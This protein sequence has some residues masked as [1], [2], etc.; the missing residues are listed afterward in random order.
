IE[1]G[2]DA[3]GHPGAQFHSLA[4]FSQVGHLGLLVHLAADAVSQI[5]LDDPVTVV[6]PD[7][8][9][10]GPDVAEAGAVAHRPEPG[11][12][13]LLGAVDQV[14]YLG[15]DLPDRHGESSVAVESLVDGSGV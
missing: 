10:G 3:Q 1:H 4:R 7:F 9:D 6:T 8:F 11:P 15:T 13:T 2:L 5:L 12:E 14:A